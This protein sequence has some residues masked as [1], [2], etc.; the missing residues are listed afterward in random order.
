MPIRRN[1]ASLA[2]QKKAGSDIPVFKR[3]VKHRNYGFRLKGST[4][5][6][7]LACG[8]FDAIGGLSLIFVVFVFHHSQVLACPQS[9]HDTAF[10]NC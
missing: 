9:K 10:P 1:A 7:Q 6:L 3:V 8:V 5:P 2:V 4:Y